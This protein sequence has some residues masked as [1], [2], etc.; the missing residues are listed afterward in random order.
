MNVTCMYTPTYLYPRTRYG[1]KLLKRADGHQDS[2][3][4]EAVDTACHRLTLVAATTGTSYFTGSIRTHTYDHVCTMM[5]TQ[6]YQ[7]H[8]AGSGLLAWRTGAAAGAHTSDRSCIV[9]SLARPRACA[10]WHCATSGG[11][12]ATT[13]PGLVML[14]TTPC[15][16]LA[17]CIAEKAVVSQRK[18]KYKWNSY[19][20][21]PSLTALMIILSFPSLWCCLWLYGCPCSPT[22]PT[23]QG[24][25][26]AL[27]LYLLSLARCTLQHGGVK[28]GALVGH[29]CLSSVSSV[30]PT[31]RSCFAQGGTAQ[32]L[33]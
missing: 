3:V 27:Q 28:Q 5:V 19:S 29:K 16:S 24:G 26:T 23:S 15:A 18:T 11:G 30:L 25:Y 33:S 8:A 13:S 9:L 2:G 32:M 17:A 22:L 12:S 1:V 4:G 20:S 6:R 14:P 10:T 7:Q 21:A 31:N